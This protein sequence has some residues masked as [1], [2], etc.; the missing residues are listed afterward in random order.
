MPLS[1]NWGSRFRWLPDFRFPVVVITNIL[2]M[3][4]FL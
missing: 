1:V 2:G 4:K 3:F